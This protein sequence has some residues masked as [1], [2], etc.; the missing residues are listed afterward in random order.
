MTARLCASVASLYKNHTEKKQKKGEIK[1]ELC[2]HNAALGRNIR[3]LHGIDLK[4]CFSYLNIVEPLGNH[5][6]KSH[7]ARDYRKN[8]GAK[9]D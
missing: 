8:D 7:A 1:V 2:G 9:K 3:F 6:I 5:A 4:Y